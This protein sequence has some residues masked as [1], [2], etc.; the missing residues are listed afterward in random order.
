MGMRNEISLAFERLL[1]T[2]HPDRPTTDE[3]ES[4]LNIAVVYTSHEATVAALK[5]A[6]A[7][8]E[9]L[10][11]HVTLVVPQAVPYHLPLE[12]P[13]VLLEFSERRF[14]E[15]ASQSP[16][17]TRVHLYLCRNPL[18][19][20]MTVLKPHSLVVLGG[21]KRWWPA[22]EKSLARKLRRAGHE[23]VFTETG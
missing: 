9:S 2:R 1:A 16:V 12:S 6:G 18:D 3:A 15:I 21:R 23:V 22:A 13:A 11:A 7:L 14:R 19:T 4:R 10:G 5:K 17:E 8:A 20:L